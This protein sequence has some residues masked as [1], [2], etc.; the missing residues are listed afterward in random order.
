MIK[1]MEEIKAFDYYYDI[2]NISGAG[3]TSLEGI[4]Y[5]PWVSNLNLADNTGLKTVDISALENVTVLQLNGCSGIET[6]DCGGNKCSVNLEGNYSAKQLTIS[7]AAKS[8][9]GAGY[10]WSQ[11]GGP[12]ILDVTGCTALTSI[13]V[14]YR[15]ITTIYVTAAQQ[16]AID[17]GTLTVRKNDSTAVTVK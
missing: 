4:E 9:S 17:A 5:F 12:E 1:T 10:S 15:N 14:S 8:I 13:N 2:F 11:Y 3:C 16:G 6:V 7:G